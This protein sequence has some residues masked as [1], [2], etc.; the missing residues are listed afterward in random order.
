M[1]EGHPLF[2]SNLKIRRARKLSEELLASKEAPPDGKPFQ[3]KYRPDPVTGVET[4]RLDTFPKWPPELG[5]TAGEIAFH[6]RSAL[7]YVVYQLCLKGGGD[8]EKKQTAFPLSESPKEYVRKR[9]KKPSYRDVSLA[10]VPEEW[11]AVIDGLQP[12]KGIPNDD[13]YHLSILNSL[14]KR[15]K[16]QVRLRCY[17]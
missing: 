2:D 12:F 9:G 10:N 17:T 11:K 8:P 6:L 5:V 3:Q 15:D 1:D 13:A 14:T 7:D 16:H 4:I